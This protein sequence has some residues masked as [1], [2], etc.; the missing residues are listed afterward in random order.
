MR[1]YAVPLFALAFLL[2]APVHAQDAPAPAP[3]P[4]AEP[5]AAAEPIAAPDAPPDAAPDAAGAAAAKAA[6]DIQL[7]VARVKFRGNR[8][9]EDD[10]I[11]VNMRTVP[12]ILLNQDVLRDDVRAIWRMGFFED[13]RVET[14][15]TAEGTIVTFVLKEKPSI[16]KIYVSGHD[17]VG[18]TKINE[19]LDLKLEEILDRAKVKKNAS[20]IRDKYI[21][22]GFYMAEVNHE[23][24]NTDDGQVDLYFRIRE[25]IKVTVSRI[26]F[27]G[28]KGQ[29]DADL[30]SVMMTSEGDLLSFMSSS[31]TYRE[32]VFQ[33]DLLLIQG[34][35]FD[36]GY[37]EVK[38]G[39]PLMELSPDRQSLFITIPIEEGKQYRIGKLKVSGDLLEPPQFYIE[40]LSARPGDLFNRSH[41]SQDRTSIEESFKDAGYA[42]VGVVPLTDKD[43]TTRIVDV[44][45]EIQKGSKVYFERIN[46]HGNSKTRDKV[47]RRE[48]RVVEGEMYNQTNLDLSKRRINQLGFFDRVDISTKRGATDDAMEVNVEVSERQTGAFQI[49]AGFSS[50]ESFILQA[51]ISQNNL[52]GRGQMLTLQA[53]LSG[54]RRLF[55]LQFQDSYFLDTRWTFGFNLFNQRRFFFSFIRD[56]VGGS[57]TWGYML[58]DWARLFLT[59]TAED[60]EV[61][62]SARGSLF[63]AGLRNPLPQGSLANLLRSGLTSSW[64]VSL[65][66]DTRDNRMFTHDG[67]FNTISAEF[68]EPAFF[69]QNT[70]TRY[71]AETRFFYPI[72][73]PFVLRSRLGTGLI[74]SRSP[75]GVPIFERYFV[76]GIFDVRG[77][78]PRSLGPRIRAPNDQAP[79][80][81]LGSFVVG[82]NLQVIGNLEIEFPIIPKVDIRGV[83]FAD[84]GNAFNLE[85]QYCRLRPPSAHLSQDPCNVIFPLGS[86]RSSWGFGFRWFSPIGPL[87]FEW[88]IPTNPLPGERPLVFEFTIGN[89][90]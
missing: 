63:A 77:F 22:R 33:R 80:A 27:V 79:D 50:V 16:R 86:L 32:E 58:S 8:K 72:W 76:G 34:Q 85:D 45:F 81:G 89:F 82:G 18:L 51:Q 48:M 1:L 29:T 55:M 62:T 3:A 21:E 87:R 78:S 74:S 65:Q 38:V 71:E 35:Y 73:G 84:M 7:E 88:G 2:G 39:E 59:Y 9:V 6:A 52:L 68:A 26:N 83:I 11:R 40:R 23:I 61:S 25:N 12:G 75:Q 67:W 42:Y 41:L 30:R 44:N 69:S 64:R 49:G 17:E 57:L 15:S 54:L 20:K 14:A 53:Q 36:H 19:V 47:I 60:V 4:V 56:A 37:I 46:V 66:H 31:G 5:A 13:I 24:K 90:F 70:F 10:A 28:N 43:D